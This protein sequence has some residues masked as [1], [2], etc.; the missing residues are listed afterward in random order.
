MVFGQIY[1]VFVCFCRRFPSVE[2][3]AARPSSFPNFGRQRADSAP[4]QP[5][6]TEA[7]APGRAHM[8]RPPRPSSFGEDEMTLDGFTYRQMS[9]DLTGVKTMLLKLKRVL[10]DVSRPKVTYF[11]NLLNQ[12]HKWQAGPV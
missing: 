3:K 7:P 9:Q 10:Q 11:Y 2:G 12:N 1:V 6:E 5:A 4:T 8:F